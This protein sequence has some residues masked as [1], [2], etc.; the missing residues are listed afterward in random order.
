LPASCV[1][2]AEAR[3]CSPS[4]LMISMSCWIMLRSLFH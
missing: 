3:A 2:F 1:N 4:L